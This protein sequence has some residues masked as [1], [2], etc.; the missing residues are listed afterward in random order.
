[1]RAA[2]SENN[3][4]QYVQK[5]DNVLFYHGGVLNYFVEKYVSNSKYNDEGAVV[6]IINQLGRIE[7]WKSFMRCLY[8]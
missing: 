4:I 2:V 6:E 1:M 7:R 8:V 5:I 3:L